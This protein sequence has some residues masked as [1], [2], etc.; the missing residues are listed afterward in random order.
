MARLPYKDLDDLPSSVRLQIMEFGELNVDRMLA[1]A[2]T[3]IG[4]W[5]ETFHSILA[6]SSISST[7][8]E[9]V[10]LRIAHLYQCEYELV[11]HEV[12][13]RTVG[14]T[15]EE[16]DAVADDEMTSEVLSDADR[17]VLQL[18]TEVL[19]QHETTDDTFGAVHHYLGTRG[20]VE[21]MILIGLYSGL[22]LL[23][24]TLQVDVDLTARM[25]FAP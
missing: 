17:T 8:R 19:T 6:A 11:Q 7:Q 2:T 22:A 18:V 3:V 13:G 20:T 14:L 23:L 12:S 10:I 16:M 25:R 24:N 5:H 21:L 15:R 4:P 1:H 9:L